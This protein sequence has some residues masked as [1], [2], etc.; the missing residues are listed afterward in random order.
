M[1]SY[2]YLAW[3]DDPFAFHQ[4]NVWLLLQ[5]IICLNHGWHFSIGRKSRDERKRIRQKVCFLFDKFQRRIFTDDNTSQDIISDND[6]FHSSNSLNSIKT[7]LQDDLLRH[8][9]LLFF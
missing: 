7:I 8:S 4:Q 9:Q 2:P 6:A 5:E 3:M 1:R